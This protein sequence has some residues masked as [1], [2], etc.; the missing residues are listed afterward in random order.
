M[1]LEE[2]ERQ[3]FINKMV[4]N[5]R[6]IISNQVAIPLGVYKMNQI[7]G[8][9]EPYK[10]ANDIDVS[11]FRDYDLNVDELPIGTERLQWNIEKLIEFENEF[12]EVN[13]TYKADI[14]RTCR[15]LIDAYGK[16][17]SDD[18]NKKDE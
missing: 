1:T 7:I 2:K 17:A 15:K 5:A 10:E 14:L 16:T 18:S 13:L 6:A 3:R 8:W 11:I 12:D 9:L 4:S